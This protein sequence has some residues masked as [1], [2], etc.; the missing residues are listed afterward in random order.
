[1]K[2]TKYDLQLTAAQIR[3]EQAA[4]RAQRR[5]EHR[6][7]GELLRRAAV[8]GDEQLDMRYLARLKA[9][10]VPETDR[11]IQVLREKIRARRN[12]VPV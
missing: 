2:H 11:Q 9:A 6:H 3:R 5:A 4:E 1:M 10:G 12:G 7:M 8:L